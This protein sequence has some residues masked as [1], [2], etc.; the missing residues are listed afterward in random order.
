M[1]KVLGLWVGDMRGNDPGVVDGFVLY[2]ASTAALFQG[3]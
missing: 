3:I 2:V 1:R